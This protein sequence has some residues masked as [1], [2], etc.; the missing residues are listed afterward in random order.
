MTSYRQIAAEALEVEDEAHREKVLAKYPDQAA[1]VRHILDGLAQQL[2]A[3]VR[4]AGAA[5]RPALT[6]EQLRTAS[7]RRL[8]RIEPAWL[9][10]RVAKKLD[11]QRRRVK[12]QHRK[13]REALA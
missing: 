8:E 9:R 7:Q 6:T 13:M 10:R 2:T 11:E 12:E 5:T 1:G 3:S 4:Y